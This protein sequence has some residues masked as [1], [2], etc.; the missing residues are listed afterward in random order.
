MRLKATEYLHKDTVETNDRVDADVNVKLILKL[1][2]KRRKNDIN[3]EI[4]RH[5]MLCFYT[6]YLNI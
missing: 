3:A 4:V 2:M 1:T 6:A 5:E